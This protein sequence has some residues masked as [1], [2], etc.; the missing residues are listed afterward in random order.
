MKQLHRWIVPTMKSFPFYDEPVVY[1]CEVCGERVSSKNALADADK[2]GCLS[3][4]ES[5][6]GRKP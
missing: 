2:K 3:T 5:L 6:A 1:T 4:E